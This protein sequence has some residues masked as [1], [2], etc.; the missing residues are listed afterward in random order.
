MKITIVIIVKNEECGISPCLDSIIEQIGQSDCEILI[1]D[2]ASSDNTV[3]IVQG[4][5]DKYD[6]VRIIQCQKYGY[7][8]Q[9]NVGAENALG[10]YVLYVS[11]DT[12]FSPKLLKKYLTYIDDYDVIQGTIVNISNGTRFSEI[13]KDVYPI[14]YSGFLGTDSESFSTV[15]VAIRR[16]LI[17]DRSFDETLNSF[18]DKEWYHHY[19]GMVRFKRLK[20]AAIY[21]NVHESF[22]Q[23]GRKIYKEAVA[24]GTICK[25]NQAQKETLNYFNWLHFSKR[26]LAILIPS[27]F[28]MSIVSVIYTNALFLL[29]SWLLLVLY[30][31]NYIFGIVKKYKNVKSKWKIGGICY[32]YL[33]F[34]VAGILKG[35]YRNDRKGE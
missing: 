30:K 27:V 3:K 17:L 18:E 26:C 2:G 25:R 10:E 32:V 24:L 31:M 20:S 15:N 22:R 5:V 34:V 35:Y 29:I 19:D 21:H 23:Y 28:L 16:S 4:Y 9:R 33:D 13:M 14:F 12:V 8:Y 11:G 6:F 7:S 1:V